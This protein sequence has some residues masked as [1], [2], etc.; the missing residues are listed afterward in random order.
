MKVALALCLLIIT[1]A[2]GS[3]LVQPWFSANGRYQVSHEDREYGRTYMVD[4]KTG[5]VWQL[6]FCKDIAD[7]DCFNLVG[8][9]GKE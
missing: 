7:T 8:V 1:L 9:E 4:T 6:G 5:K 2:A 3:L